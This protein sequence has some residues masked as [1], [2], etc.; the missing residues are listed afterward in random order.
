[1]GKIAKLVSVTLKTRVIVEDNLSEEQIFEL[2]KPRLSN[3]LS[4]NGFE[5][6]E[7]I[8]DDIECPYDKD[9]DNIYPFPTMYV[10]VD[11][12]VYDTDGENVDLPSEMTIELPIDESVD[13]SDFISDYI[14]NKTGFLVESFVVDYKFKVG[15]DVIAPEP[16]RNDMW[17]FGEWI[18]TIESIKTDTDGTTYAEVKDGDGD[19]FC[20]ALN[21]L[22][23]AED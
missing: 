3:N 22:K 17:N 15:D 8:V 14:S 13:I 12:I 20:I 5:N 6:L 7:E 9:F 2:A 1:M 18:G 21:R 11:S 10:S 4:T 23:L 16:I 19:I